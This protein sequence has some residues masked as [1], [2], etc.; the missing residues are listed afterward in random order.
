MLQSI[1]PLNLILAIDGYKF[2]HVFEMPKEAGYTY[3]VIVPRK[4][5]KYASEIVAMG[6]SFV[7]SILNNVRITK[8]DI[9]EAEREAFSQGYEFNREGWELILTRYNGALPLQ[10]WGVKEGQVVS[11]QTPILAIANTDEDFAWL[12]TYIEPWVQSTVWKMSTVASTMRVCRSIILNR[13]D[14][15]GTDRA[16]VNYKL[17]NF[18]DR[19]AD[20]P[21]EAATIAGIA[22]AALFDGSDC[23]RAPRYIRA[24]FKDDPNY[25]I[26]TSVEATEHSVTTMN[27]DSSNQDDF[28]AA[29]MAVKRLQAVV[30]RTKKGIGIPVLSVVIDT[31][32][33]RRFVRDYMGTQLK[34]EILATGG[35]VVFRPD[36]GDPTVEPSLVAQDIEATFGLDGVTKTGHKILNRQTSVI[37]GD[38]LNV[39]TIDDILGGWVNAGYSMDSFLVG[40]GGGVTNHGGRDDFSFS[41]KAVAWMK[42][43]ATS[44]E[45]LL[46]EPKTDKGKKSLS[47]LVYVA[48]EGENLVTKTLSNDTMPDQLSDLMDSDVWVK[49]CEN[50][51]RVHYQSF[52]SVRTLART[53]LI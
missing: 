5:S 7:T 47:G 37:Q 29:K 17:H 13:M 23:V 16:G 34:D 51:V 49:W 39:F 52:E 50:G 18:G 43:D 22:H 45:N 27:S 53:G 4:A 30:D 21:D 40:M 31:Y 8:E 15:T 12:P 9:D 25:V 19:G 36:S 26:T 42:K 2:T 33:S 35:V 24:M 46:K 14:E 41:M 38:G 10:V 6:Q 1:K 28:G 32:D 3:G 48:K 44:W 11:P 20:S